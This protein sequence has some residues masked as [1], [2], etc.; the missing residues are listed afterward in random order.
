MG[1][2]HPT[3]GNP[4][5]DSSA[6]TRIGNTINAVSFRQGKPVEVRQGVIVPGKTFTVTGEGPRG[7]LMPIDGTAVNRPRLTHVPLSF[8]I[9]FPGG[10]AHAPRKPPLPRDALGKL[11]KERSAV[12]APTCN[13]PP[14]ASA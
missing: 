1:C 10:P 7:G 14:V 13:G 8:S 11:E 6:Y 5:Y 9:G 2:L 12:T 3:T 4:V